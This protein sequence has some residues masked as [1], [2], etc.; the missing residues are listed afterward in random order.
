[1]KNC[2][3]IYN[4]N[5]NFNNY[6]NSKSTKNNIIRNKRLKKKNRLCFKS[7]SKSLT[8]KNKSIQNKRNN[9]ITRFSKHIIK[10]LKKKKHCFKCLKNDYLTRNKDALY[11][12]KKNAIKEQTLIKFA[13]I[14]I[15]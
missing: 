3:R 9:F 10:R 15:K 1:M 7:K 4:D 13:H 12:Y 6:K 2:R 8:R 11:K 5:I 14:N